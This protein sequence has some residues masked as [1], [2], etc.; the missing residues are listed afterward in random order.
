MKI[1]PKVKEIG[2]AVDANN[3]EYILEQVSQYDEDGHIVAYYD[4]STAWYRIRKLASN[5][6]PAGMLNYGPALKKAMNYLKRKGR[7]NA[8]YIPA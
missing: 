4:D 2:Y 5:G 8:L 7:E 3:M 6:M 1:C